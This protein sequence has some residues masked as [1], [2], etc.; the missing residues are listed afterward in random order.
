MLIAHQ[1]LGAL[2]GP[3]VYRQQNIDAEF[4]KSTSARECARRFMCIP[5]PRRCM[6]LAATRDWEPRIGVQ[7]VMVQATALWSDRVHQCFSW[8][9]SAT[10][11][12]LCDDTARQ[13]TPADNVGKT[14]D[15]ERAV[16]RSCRRQRRAAEVAIVFQEVFAFVSI[17]VRKKTGH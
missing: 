16:S 5:S 17:M 14:L 2:A 1:P 3:N 4:L 7:R 8:R 11:Q 15:T 12:R 9:W 13:F 6:P 10:A